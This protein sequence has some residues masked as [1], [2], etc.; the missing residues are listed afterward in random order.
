MGPAG[1][2]HG[3]GAGLGSS[4]HVC[5]PPPALHPPCLSWPPSP[6]V[7]RGRYTAEVT[8]EEI[9]RCFHM[10]AEDACKELR[11]GLTILKRLCRRFGIGR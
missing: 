9:E 8:R 7:R 3:R 1:V 5:T 11:I 6:P 2:P 10:R 4:P